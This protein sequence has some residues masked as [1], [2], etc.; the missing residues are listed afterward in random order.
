MLN[1]GYPCEVAHLTEERNPRGEEEYMT[2]SELDLRQSKLDATN[3]PNDDE[4][5]IQKSHA[6]HN[7]DHERKKKL[8]RTLAIG[9]RVTT[10]VISHAPGLGQ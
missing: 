5:R 4:I 10:E 8:K 6:S 9:H 2:N 3:R 1:V 7:T